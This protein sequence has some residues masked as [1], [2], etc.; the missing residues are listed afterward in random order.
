MKDKRLLYVLQSEIEVTTIRF[1]PKRLVMIVLNVLLVLCSI[2][3]LASGVGF[4]E[5]NFHGLEDPEPIGSYEKVENNSIEQ[6][7][8]HFNPHD[9]RTWWMV[10]IAKLFSEFVQVKYHST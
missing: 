6:P 3:P 2:N 9:N 10:I 4:R 7:L 8:D 1:L 5:F